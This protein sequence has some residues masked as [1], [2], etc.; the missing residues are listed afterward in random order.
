M[1]QCP[2]DY[3]LYNDKNECS[4]CEEGYVYF[5]VINIC[6]LKTDCN[7]SN[8][9]QLHEISNHCSCKETTPFF[10]LNNQKCS[11]CEQSNPFYEPSFRRK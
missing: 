11:A 10:D 2:N 8:N 5:P 9:Q 1:D 6:V 4:S 3:P 7:E